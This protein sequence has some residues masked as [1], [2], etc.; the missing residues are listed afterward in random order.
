MKPRTVG[1]AD[2][3]RHA[4]VIQPLKNAM[5]RGIIGTLFTRHP[6]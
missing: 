6:N 1:R 3:R 5:L 4:A 2:R